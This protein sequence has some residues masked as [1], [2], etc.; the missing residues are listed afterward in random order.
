MV[1]THFM[2][3]A[4]YCDRVALVH[5]ARLIALDTP[6][7]LK[8]MVADDALP[9]PTMEDAFIRLIE[10]QNAAQDVAEQVA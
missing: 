7:R 2:D 5:R 10:R 8:A 3:E 1:T 4:E 9:D 6:D